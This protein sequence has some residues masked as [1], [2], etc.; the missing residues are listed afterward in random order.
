M[1]SGH[2]L[3]PSGD[4]SQD[5]RKLMEYGFQFGLFDNGTHTN[6]QQ[7]GGLVLKNSNIQVPVIRKFMLSMG[8][9]FT[10]FNYYSLLN[11]II[12]SP[13]WQCQYDI[14]MTR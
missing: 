4:N 14:H 9:N 6:K 8:Q 3:E 7:L 13:S 5:S 12:N 10:Y 1:C 2:H 11:L